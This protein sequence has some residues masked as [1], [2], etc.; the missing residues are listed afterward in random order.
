MTDIPAVWPTFVCR[1]P[2]AEIRFLVDGLGFAERAVHTEGDTVV[3]AELTWPGTVPGGVM[4]GPLH[5]AD[6][7]CGRPPGGSSIHVVVDGDV[8]TRFARAVAAG[9]TAVRE[10]E[11]TDYGSR[12]FVVADPEGNLWS[13]GTWY[14]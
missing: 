13:V 8:D 1:D 2:R 5:A 10:P 6:D 4:L 7:P 14:E 12:Q 9:A 3:H 11:D